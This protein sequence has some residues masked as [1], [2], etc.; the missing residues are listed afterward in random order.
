MICVSG[1]GLS[2]FDTSLE[3]KDVPYVDA[4]ASRSDNGQEVYVKIVN[5]HTNE[6]ITVRIVVRGVTVDIAK[7]QLLTADS[8]TIVNSF[9][10]PE[11]I[12]VQDIELSSTTNL[13]IKLP[14]HSVSVI[15]LQTKPELAARNHP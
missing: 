10:K 6:A 8:L 7:Q 2:V 11:A 13:H 5:A 14:K 9:A 4:V 3:G 12:K 1:S 15:T